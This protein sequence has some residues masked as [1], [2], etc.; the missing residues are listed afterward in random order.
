MSSLGM[1]DTYAEN[2]WTA[3]KTAFRLT[4]NPLETQKSRCPE[5]VQPDL[6]IAAQKEYLEITESKHAPPDIGRQTGREWHRHRKL[7]EKK[8]VSRRHS[9]MAQR[10]L[11]SSSVTD[12]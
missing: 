8:S 1:I 11:L 10:S 2:M 5:M 9:S 4:I 3:E 7:H 12:A 6:S